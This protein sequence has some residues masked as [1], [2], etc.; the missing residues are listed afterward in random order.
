MSEDL[1]KQDQNE[2]APEVQRQIQLN[3]EK[4]VCG[5]SN[6]C[7]VVGTPE[8]LIIDFG[9]NPQ[10]VGIPTIP[11]NISQRV[12]LNYATAKRML[13]ALQQTI[14]RHEAT[15]GV[16]E[17]DLSRRVARSGMLSQNVPPVND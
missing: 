12:V 11:I 7:R 4:A 14:Q 10:P 8:E 3:D 17:I 16:V 5:Y 2:A 15:F 13:L 1:V 9:L 6:F